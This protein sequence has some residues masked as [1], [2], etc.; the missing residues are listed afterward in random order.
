M[1][2]RTLWKRALICFFLGYLAMVIYSACHAD[3]L[4]NDWKAQTVE[5]NAK[6]VH[7]VEETGGRYLVTGGDPYIVFED[8]NLILVKTLSITFEEPFAETTLVDVYY[9]D[10]GEDFSE[11]RKFHG[12]IETGGNSVEIDFEESDLCAFRVDVDSEPGTIFAFLEI[13]AVAKDLDAGVPFAL[14]FA[15]RFI[16]CYILLFA[17][18]LLLQIKTAFLNRGYDRLKGISETILHRELSGAELWFLW[19]TV[20]LVLCRIWLAWNTPLIADT[21]MV[22]DDAGLMNMTQNLMKGNWLGEYSQYTMMKGV[23]YSLLCTFCGWTRIPYSFMLSI[24][25]ISAA[26]YFVGSL[27]TVMRSYYAQTL[28]FWMLIY[29]PIGFHYD[30]AQ[31]LYRNALT[32]PFTL[33]IF[34]GIFNVYFHI[35]EPRRA[36]KSAVVAGISL[37]LFWNLRED[38]V[39]ILPFVLT[40]SILAFVTVL[41]SRRKGELIR[42]ALIL[43]LPFILFLSGNLLISGINYS[44]Y[45]IFATND[46]TT[47]V[48]G[49]VT[50]LFIQIDYEDTDPDVDP[51]LCYMSLDKFEYIIDHSESLSEYKEIFMSAYK[52]WAENLFDGD[53]V[54]GDHIQWCFRLGLEQAGFYR[55]GRLTQEYLKAVN[56]E[57]QEAIASGELTLQSGLFL[58]NSTKVM[59]AGELLECVAETASDMVCKVFSYSDIS[60]RVEYSTGSDEEIREWEYVVN[61]LLLYPDEGD[62]EQMRLSEWVVR[63]ENTIISIYQKTS[64]LLLLASALSFATV[65]AAQIW[66]LRRREKL[67]FDRWMATC[68]MILSAFVLLYMFTVYSGW[69]ELPIAYDASGLYVLVEGFQILSIYSGLNLLSRYWKRRRKESGSEKTD[70]LCV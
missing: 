43:I 64:M 69:L 4:L 12:V 53:Y 48:F 34:G 68:A 41:L 14:Y 55:D 45:G 38:S 11:E 27:R 58:P 21:V 46:R 67:L 39:W 16:L 8:Q 10:E 36:V 17:L 3:K 65:S 56:Q 19:G 35:R 40:A 9:A 42:T 66:N 29:S 23:T 61:S 44:Y 13:T 7:D 59:S 54:C 1:R 25:L 22:H 20:I 30:V 60:A 47:S 6:A 37:F 52:L 26:Y 18:A 51:A 28:L 5:L 50:G 49:E 57:L 15:N 62:S 2:N 63:L 24:F 31:R 70:H 33:L 32:V